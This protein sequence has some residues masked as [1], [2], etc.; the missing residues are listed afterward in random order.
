MRFNQIIMT[1]FIVVKFI[2]DGESIIALDYPKNYPIPLKGEK[3]L[4]TDRGKEYDGTV[5]E[6]IFIQRKEYREIL[7][8]VNCA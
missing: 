1:E 6:R 8:I 7:L 4:M 3:L 5:E 2:E